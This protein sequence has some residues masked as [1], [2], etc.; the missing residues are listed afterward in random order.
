MEQSV[1]TSNAFFHVA[2]G[3]P[4]SV[5]FWLVGA[6]AGSFV[7]SAFAWVFGIK[8][9]KPISMIASVQAIVM[10]L[11]VPLI[12]IADLGKPWRFIYLLLPANWH[13]TAPMSW[14]A[15]LILSYPVSMFIYT[16]FCIKN[17]QKWA[18]ILGIVA[19][20]LACSTHW[21]TG[22]VMELNPGRHLNHTA[23]A[24]ILFL[25]GAFISGI[26]ILILIIWIYNM[27][28][29]AAKRIE[30]SLVEEMATYMK[31]G[32]GFDAFLLWCEFLQTVYG[33]ESEYAAH[34]YIL[35]GVFYFPYVW[36]ETIIG[37]VIPFAILCTPLKK[38]KIGVV[39][40]AFL[41]AIGVYGMRIWWVLGGQY[42]Q[43]FY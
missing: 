3:A 36:L 9:Y 17:D 8:R 19:I 24:P 33:R 38:T 39:T 5:Y 34:H 12:L 4:I 10:L 1:I 40:A 41:V 16:Y 15:I 7:I 21:Y 43:Q 28:V 37:L 27:I 35:G 26:G 23:M 2:W 14:G 32:I 29:A 11:I 6:S 30:W 13:G 25:T 31:Y 42:M 22:V 20:I 18:K